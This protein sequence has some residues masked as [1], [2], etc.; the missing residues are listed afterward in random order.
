MSVDDRPEGW[1]VLADLWYPGWTCTIDGEST[2]I[3][4]ADSVFRAVPAAA[5]RHTIEMTF[6]PRSYFI[7]RIITLTTLAALAVAGLVRFGRIFLR[8]RKNATQGSSSEGAGV[9]GLLV[10]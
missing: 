2:P 6:A 7:G 10:S 9:A 4:R 5:G 1:L 3:R 8:R